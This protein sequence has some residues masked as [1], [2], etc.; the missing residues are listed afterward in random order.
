[1]RTHEKK[2]FWKFFLTYFGSVALLILSSGYFYFQ[3]QQQQMLRAENFEL[4][5]YARQFKLQH[6]KYKDPNITHTIVSLSRN[7]ITI[8][9]LQ[10]KDGYFIK[11][12]PHDWSGN[13]LYIKKS[14]KFYEK[15]VSKLRIK[16]ISF[17]IFLLGLFA[18]ISFILARQALRPMQD[19]ISKLDSFAKDLIHDLNTPVTSILLNMKILQKDKNFQNSRA[20][21]RIKTNTQEISHLHTNLTTLLQE[22]T[23]QLEKHDICAL[24]QEIINT[25]KL[26]FTNLNFKLTCKPN[27]VLINS[28]ALHQIISSIVSNACKYNK[29]HGSITV[30]MQDKTLQIEDTGIGIKDSEK[31]FERNF[32]EH[33]HSSGLGLDIVKRLCDAMD[34]NI[35]IRSKLGVG[36]TFTLVFR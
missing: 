17:Q 16:I 22:E 14:T 35:S 21:K 32:T 30:T 27:S 20:L 12:V 33:T 4:I 11:Y 23:F 19:M 8:E 6:G 29:K 26:L 36:S 1:M 2:A 13:Y 28:K 10:Q 5:D 24:I 9:N 34:I 15:N 31:V 3:E 7:D 25:H 18:L